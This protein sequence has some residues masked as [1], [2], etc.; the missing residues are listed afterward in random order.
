MVTRSISP[1]DDTLIWAGAVEVEHTEEWS[2]PWRLPFSRI[3]LFPGGKLAA[4]A[5]M[6]A[7]VRIV[8]GTDSTTVGGRVMPP[9]E[10]G[11]LCPIDLVVDG[12]MVA[13]ENMTG[14]TTF[15]F[16]GLSGDAKTVELWLP[17]AGQLRIAE[18]TV[19]AEAHLW[20]PELP[21]MPRLLV[22]GSSITQC[23]DAASPTATWPALVARELGFDLT[24]LGFN[25]EC[26][27]DPMVA[28]VIRDRPADLIVMCLGANV[29]GNGSFNE[30][31]F[32][33]AVLGLLATVRDGHPGVPIVVVSPIV[34]P[35][36]ETVP[37]KCGMTLP[38][39]RSE[40]ATAVRLL[41]EHGDDNLHGIDG[42]DVFG[43]AHAHLLS[44]EVHPDAEGYRLMGASLAAHLRE[45]TGGR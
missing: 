4:G 6:G 38:M 17:Q 35:P 32:L 13:T 21:A 8:F 29:Y 34:S 20:R 1:A 22:Y 42:L 36:K 33:P 19:D 39:M 24:C 44:D 28:R 25:G 15:E 10:G 7:G 2:R 12:E 23:G 14:R 43:P 37:G 31:S 5:A 30:R 27:L 9:P 18:L 41:T 40:I 3:D 26:H 45:L 16:A 11:W